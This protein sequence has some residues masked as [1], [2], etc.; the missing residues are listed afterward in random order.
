MPWWGVAIGIAAAIAALAAAASALVTLIVARTVVTPPKAPTDDLYVLDVDAAAGT[1]TLSTSPESRTPGSYGLWFTG[2]RGYAKIGEVLGETLDS[3]VRRVETVESGD[4]AKALRARITG[5]YYLDPREL[6]YPTEDVLIETEFGPAPAW[7]VPVEASTRWVI[8]VHGRAVKREET[9]RGVPVFHE[10]GFTSLLIS[11]RNDGDAPASPDGRYALGDTEWRDVD[12]AI[13][14]AIDH[15]ATDV[16]LMGWSMGGAT[17]LQA[18]TRS[19]HAGIVRAVALDSPVVDW[20]VALRYQ[21]GLRRLPGAV[22]DGALAAIGRPWGG[23]LTGQSQP[24]DLARLDWVSRAK[25]LHV[26]ILL[27]HSDDD[28][29]I[30]STAS[31][32]LAAERPDIVTFEAFSVAGHTRLWNYDRVRWNGA[33]SRWLESPAVTERFS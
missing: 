5:W 12:A 4:L 27:M 15:G 8:Q 28:V 13:R 3:V 22:S 9:I 6:G 19:E 20:I 29:F 17:V 14:Y 30:P 32:A 7:L 10:H 11:Y 25:D 21:G 1:V 31:R 2:E 33:I 16:V 23:R 18:I 26:P 24:I